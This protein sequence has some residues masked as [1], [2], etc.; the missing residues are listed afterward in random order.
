MIFM[1]VHLL[2]N[3]FLN[4]KGG[5]DHDFAIFLSVKLFPRPI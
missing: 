4:P 2:Y 3:H 1:P 5:Y